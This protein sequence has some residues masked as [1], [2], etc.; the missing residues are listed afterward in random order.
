MNSK[1]VGYIQQHGRRGAVVDKAK[2]LGILH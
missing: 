2:A 1:I